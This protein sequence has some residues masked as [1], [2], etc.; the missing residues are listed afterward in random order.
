MTEVEARI[1]RLLVEELNLDI[2]PEEIPSDDPLI[3]GLGMD[4]AGILAVVSSLEEE[5]DIELEDD[6][7]T[8]E[9][10]ETVA[11]IA[12]VVRGKGE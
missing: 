5:F 11:S 3:E 4:S 6:E 12:A 8:R 10:F 2:S 1:K 7:I 9:T